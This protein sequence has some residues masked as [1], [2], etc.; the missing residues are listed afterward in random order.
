[1]GKVLFQKGTKT[2]FKPKKEKFFSKAKYP[3]ISFTDEALETG[4]LE[5]VAL[6]DGLLSKHG[7][8]FQVQPETSFGGMHPDNSWSEE[9]PWLRTVM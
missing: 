7:L 6:F 4:L 1:M 5:C 9:P 8:E 3:T 2:T